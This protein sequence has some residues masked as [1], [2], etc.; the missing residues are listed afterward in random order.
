MT[1]F[2]PY[3]E[4]LDERFCLDPQVGSQRLSDYLTETLSSDERA[5]FEHHLS[6]CLKCQ[7][8]LVYLSWVLHQV[9]TRPRPGSSASP[10]QDSSKNFTA[11][12]GELLAVTSLYDWNQEDLTHAYYETPL[13]ERLA[14]STDTSE[15]L[16]FPVTV[17]Y[18]GGLAIGQ[19]WRR[20]GQL[21]YRLTKSPPEH[22][23]CLLYF[24]ITNPSDAQTFEVR[25]NVEQWL[26]EVRAFIAADTPAAIIHALKQ[27]HLYCY[28]PPN[29]QKER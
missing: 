17:E 24:P 12:Y 21:S 13:V 16:T 15:S 3:P 14:A 1:T 4:P 11:Q 22:V 27:F 5:E 2:Y 26:G 19:F 7:E 10:L 8:E 9:A 29:E 20:A 18:A 6:Y 25:P 28:K 23:S